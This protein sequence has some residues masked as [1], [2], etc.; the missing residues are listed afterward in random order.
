VFSDADEVRNRVV[1]GVVDSASLAPTR[2][3]LIEFGIPASAL[4]LEVTGPTKW[5]DQRDSAPPN[6]R[7]KLS[8][9][10]GHTCRTKSVLSVAAIGRSL[11]ASR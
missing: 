10:G 8:G 11:C 7:M 3:H 5:L 9:C 2:Q 4:I 1:A 6:Q